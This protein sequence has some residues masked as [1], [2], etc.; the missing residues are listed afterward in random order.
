MDDGRDALTTDF[1]EDAYRELLMIARER[2][3]FCAFAGALEVT[4]GVLW[5]HDVDMSVHRA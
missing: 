4:S 1:T 3:A 5:R 2:H